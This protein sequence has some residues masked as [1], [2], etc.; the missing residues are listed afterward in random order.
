MAELVEGIAR[1]RPIRLCFFHGGWCAACVAQLKQLEACRHRLHAMGAVLVAASP[2][3]GELPHDLKRRYQLDIPILSDVDNA[4]SKEP[5]IAFT[6]S[7]PLLAKV[8]H[9]GIDLRRRH[10]SRC[11]GLDIFRRPQRTRDRGLGRGYKLRTKSRRHDRMLRTIQASRSLAPTSTRSGL[12]G[13]GPGAI[14]DVS[15]AT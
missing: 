6:V 4:L 8:A 15:T 9:H 1:A 5:E 3:A 12:I 13:F 2:E 7:Q 11:S 14:I 10:G